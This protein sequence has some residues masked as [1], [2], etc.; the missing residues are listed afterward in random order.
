MVAG[1]HGGRREG[2]RGT[3]KEERGGGRGTQGENVLLK[4]MALVTNFPQ[5]GPTHFPSLLIN[6]IKLSIHHWIRSRL[7]QSP[8]IDQIH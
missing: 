6:G 1:T 3:L 7:N 8:F 2:V 4:G 5:P